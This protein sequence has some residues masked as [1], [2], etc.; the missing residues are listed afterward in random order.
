MLN[1]RVNLEYYNR[2]AKGLLSYQNSK[3]NTMYNWLKEGVLIHSLKYGLAHVTRLVYKTT[4]KKVKV[5]GSFFKPIYEV[6]STTELEGV[7]FLPVGSIDEPIGCFYFMEDWGAMRK[8]AKLIEQQ[9]KYMQ[10]IV[11]TP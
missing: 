3:P 10:Q 4:E 5:D 9:I 6:K 8:R 7:Y 1:H 2:F 11:N